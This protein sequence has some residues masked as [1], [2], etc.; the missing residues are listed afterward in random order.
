MLRT[1]FKAS[2]VSGLIV[3][4]LSGS[5]CTPRPEKEYV[6]RTTLLEL[7]EN[8][9]LDCPIQTPPD[10]VAYLKL[11]SW[12]KKEDVLTKDIDRRIKDAQACNLRLQ[13]ARALSAKQKAELQKS[14]GQNAP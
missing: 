5:A 12:D 9:L 4:L 13:E 10:P 11:G 8:Y 2:M 6:Y 7:P 14:E 3:L 1:L